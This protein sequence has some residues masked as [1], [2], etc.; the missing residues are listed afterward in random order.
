MVYRWVLQGLDT[1]QIHHIHGINPPGF[2]ICLSFK[3]P[4]TCWILISFELQLL[5]LDLYNDT[6]KEEEM[7]I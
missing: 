1:E 4:E 2:T 3:G 5:L 6:Q 7:I